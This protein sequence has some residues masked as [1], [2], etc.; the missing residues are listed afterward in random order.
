MECID[1]H[2][3]IIRPGMD[4]KMSMQWSQYHFL[5]IK[6]IKSVQ[7]DYKSTIIWIFKLKMDSQN[8]RQEPKVAEMVLKI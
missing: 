4:A 1:L 6:V 8:V 2:V 3:I 7:R 5:T